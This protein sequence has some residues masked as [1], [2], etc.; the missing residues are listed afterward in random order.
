MAFAADYQGIV[1]VGGLPVPG[2]TV[3]VTQ[4]TKKTVTVTD[5]QGF[6]SFAA[7]P[8]GAAHVAVEM[9]GFAP[10]EQDVTVAAGAAL[11]KLEL[12]L[13]TLDQMRAELKP[14]LSAPYTEAQV[15]SEPAKTAE[16]PKPK[17]GAPPPA[18]P[19]EEVA[20]KANDG[21]LVNGSVNN[22][23]TSQFSLAPRFGNTASGKSLYTF[24]LNVR[25]EESALD[26]KSYSITGFN[27]PKPQT[28]DLTGGFAVQGPL[29]IPHLLRNGPNVYFGYQRTENSDSITTPGLVPTVAERL[30]DL[31]QLATATGQPIYA[32]ATG[33]SA[34]CIAAGVTPGAAFAGNVIPTP[35]ISPS[36]QTLLNLYPLPLPNL[37]GNSEYNYQIPI[38]TDTHQDAFNS[39]A[40]KTIGRK[41]Q[42]SGAFSAA[43]T[44]T[45]N[46]N[47]LGFVDSTHT[48]G[49]TTNVN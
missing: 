49:L 11:S 36:A 14:V 48:L 19:P 40:S 24:S 7:L 42:V 21:L 46:A 8:D 17:A 44:R 12:K 34:A 9:T 18:P 32:P 15:R 31:S 5:A 23:A 4:G 29:K 25:G 35:C 33:L 43:S 39:N 27:N 45:S 3:T 22:A 16:A 10:L 2:A 28:S 47:L 13:L 37:L 26:A 38:V 20:Q 1:T 30:G 6:Y 41:D